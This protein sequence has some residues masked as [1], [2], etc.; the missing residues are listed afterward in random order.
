M[1]TSR[2]S[3]ALGAASLAALLASTCA[4]AAPITVDLRVEGSTTTLYEGPVTTEA[5]LNPPGITTESSPTAEACDVKDNGANGG[6]GTA[7]GTPTTALYDASTANGLTFNAEWTKSLEDFEITRVGSDIANAGN[8]EE[9][10]GYAVNYTTAGV[11]GCQFQLAPGSEVLWAYN[12]FNL[13]HLLSLTGPTSASAGS[14]ITLHVVDGQTGA[15]I[16]GA[17]IGE[18]ISGITTTVPGSPQTNTEGNATVTLAHSGTV[19]LKATQ[20][21]S[22]RSN[23]INL[24]VHNGS[25]GTCG[26]TPPIIACPTVASSSPCEKAALPPHIPKPNEIPLIGGLANNRVFSRHRGPRVLQG[27]VQV[28]SGGTLRQV[29]IRLER[30]YKGRCFNYSGPKEK[31]TRANKCGTAQFF[32]VGSSESFSYLLPKRLPTGRYIYDIEAVNDSGQTTKLVN[33]ASEVAFRV[34]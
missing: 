20:S 27:S 3:L 26:T 19:K 1:L 17:A 31:L 10:W 4:Q 16:A 29:R 11:G 2:I 6:F 5:I 34:K 32:S 25:D 24:C 33:G 13:S 30:R 7:A 18:D 9:Y 21:E 12:Y 28:I 22:V 8:N 23:A 15:P 14:P